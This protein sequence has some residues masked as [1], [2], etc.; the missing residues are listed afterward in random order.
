MSSKIISRTHPD[1]YK[2]KLKWNMISFFGN[3]DQI[4]FT[5]QRIKSLIENFDPDSYLFT[6]ALFTLAFLN[7]IKSGQEDSTEYYEQLL[8]KVHIQY[9][10]ESAHMSRIYNL[11]GNIYYAKKDFK[12]ALDYSKRAFELSHEDIDTNIFYEMNIAHIQDAIGSYEE[13]NNIYVRVLA[14][15]ENNSGFFSFE[16]S[17][18]YPNFMKNFEKCQKVLKQDASVKFAK[19]SKYFVEF[20]EREKFQSINSTDLLDKTDLVSKRIHLAFVYGWNYF[21]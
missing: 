10:P 21:S 12:K 7:H 18:V 17:L 16:Y 2:L 14:Y 1:Q 20:R 13:A 19:R 11:I 4:D 9:C 3:S 15:L 5:I 8:Q 6:E